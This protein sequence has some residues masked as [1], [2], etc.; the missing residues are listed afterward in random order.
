MEHETQQT[1][2]PR[3]SRKSLRVAIGGVLALWMIVWGLLA[4]VAPGMVRD[5]AR[6]WAHGIGRSLEIGEVV[7]HPW[8]MSIEL[9]RVRL[10]DRN[11]QALF[12]ARHVS[13]ETMP[14]ALLIGHWHAELLAVDQPQ[15][16]VER[17]ARGSWN[18]ARFLAD[19]SGPGP[20]GKPPK[21]LL[22]TLSI[23]QGQVH[24]VDRLG[25]GLNRYELKQLNLS[26]HDL[27]T[28]PSEGGYLLSA[29]L[30]DNTRIKWRG[31]LGLAP[32]TSAGRISLTGLNL[33]SIWEY[34][35]PYLH[36]AP[37]LG[38]AAV[39]MNYIFDLK[40]SAPHLTLSSIYGRLDGLQLLAPDG[41]HRLELPAAA[42]E[43]G[44]FDLQKHS[45]FF[46]RIRLRNG[47]LTATRE[48]DGRLNWLAA[49]A[50]RP[51]SAKQEKP[52]A[53]WKMQVN[54]LR[55]ENW[56]L[57]VLDSSFIRPLQ[58]KTEIPLLSFGVRQSTQQ[59][60]AIERL[61]AILKNLQLGENGQPPLIKT[62][63]LQLSGASIAE[64]QIHPGAL[65]LQQPVVLL[66]RAASGQIN[67]A[68][69]L[70]SRLPAADPGSTP[71]WKWSVPRVGVS[72][73]QL[74]WSDRQ[75]TQ[76]VQVALE[77][78]SGSLA[79][80]AA[81]SI[82]DADLTAS[83]GKGRLG[84]NAAW[85]TAAGTAR[86]TVTANGLPLTPLAPYLLGGTPLSLA[87]GSASARLDLSLDGGHWMLSGQAGVADL[88]VQEP[89]EAAPLLAWHGLNLNGLKLSGQP[90]AL[91]V[92]DV[93]L[94]RPQARL[95]LD[96]HRVSNMR[97]LFAG[98]AAAKPAAA[99]AKTTTL[100]DI[101]AVHVRN[102]NLDFADQ[103]M[104]PAFATQINHLTG[105]VTGLSSRPGRR[106]T[107]A[108]NGEVDQAGDVR[109]RGA[110]AP[111]AI[112]DNADISL[113]FRNIPLTSLNTYSENIAGWQI[114][115][116]RLSV[117]LHYVLS[118][119]KL[120]GDN[121]IVVDSIKLGPQV[122]RPGVSRLPLSLA[123]AV[124]EDSDGRIDL[125]LPVSGNLDDPQF[126]YGGLVWQAFVNVIQKV[127]TAP[128]RALGSLFG[129]DNFDNVRFIAGEAAVTPPERQKLGQLAQMLS[130]RPQLK[131]RLAGAYDPVADR[132]AMAR[133]RV[134][135][136]IL[137]AAGAAPAAGEPLPEIDLQDV[138][139]Q[140][141]IKS[142]Y[143][144][145]VGRL[146]LLARMV[147]DSAKPD[148]YARLRNEAIADE[149]VDDAAL[150]ALARARAQSAQQFLL[151]SQPGLASRVALD[152]VHT[153]RASAD[154]VPL[155]IDLVGH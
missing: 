115:D 12:A 103:A 93:V 24:L 26:L 8:S 132:K 111:L 22:D 28:L 39:D 38:T 112:T 27:S 137:Q 70:V 35:S 49:L 144:Q 129:L 59:G 123:V 64:H 78:I 50:P 77:H 141:A 150:L 142:M 29:S 155:L 3:I 79:P 55:F 75:S 131:L 146:K 92:R 95:V 133:A 125:R 143:A 104:K 80:R 128:L 81:G 43:D 89:G 53:D 105:S 54:D 71:A 20:A 67:L 82:F 4:F 15:W 138:E 2:L 99:P 6:Q 134:D 121:R 86:G 94:D 151:Q 10:S 57:G 52:A 98:N 126:S 135:L 74:R 37:P 153:T 85:D 147:S 44:I 47:W 51:V 102:G 40:G 45:L 108:L 18:W 76:P 87:R 11:G 1:R 61:S 130:Q 83:A 42:L 17:D 33:A 62:A 21:V 107:L 73:G 139:M 36:L 106:G 113:L 100:V 34:A 119:R 9:D 136:A 145:R 14:R 110:L 120:N 101:R 66:E 72:D 16:F 127:A 7:I 152:P 149:A 69:L 114:Q 96:Q 68:S 41:R 97:R 116:G 109:V 31:S 32:L 48:A 25:G 118:Q 19:A 154:G 90:L 65:T 124:L 91:S 88:A 84:L 140:A 5:A 60:L 117:D 46:K 23:A 148:F 122:E 56:N 13:L 58:I 30:G 63:Q